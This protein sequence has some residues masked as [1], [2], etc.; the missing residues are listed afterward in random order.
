MVEAARLVRVTSPTKRYL[1]VCMLS[2]S[3]LVLLLAVGQMILSE[4]NYL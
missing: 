2:L 1:T 3:V 4:L